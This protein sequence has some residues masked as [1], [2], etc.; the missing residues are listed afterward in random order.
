MN[1]E[2]QNLISKAISYIRS[3]YADDLTIA[4]VADHAGFCTDYFNR[5][6]RARTGFTVME[7]VRFTRLSRAAVLLR[8][9]SRDITDIAFECGYET[10]ES[11]TR[12]FGSLYGRSPSE[13]RSYYE[14]VPLTYADIADKTN[15]VR[16][17]HDHPA[18]HPVDTAVVVDELLQKDAIRYGINA[19]V[20][21]E[22][23]G[24]QFVSDKDGS[25]IGMDTFGN[26]VYADIV[27]DDPAKIA[28]Y[29]RLLRGFAEGTSFSLPG[30]KSDVVRTMEEYG[31]SAEPSVCWWMYRGDILPHTPK[32]TIR[33]LTVED[34]PAVK[35]FAAEYG[36][37][38]KVCESLTQRD[39]YH[40]ARGDEPLGIYDN[41]ELI[42]IFRTMIYGKYG[43]RIGELEG[44]AVLSRYKNAAFTREAY[45]M[46]INHLVGNSVM[47]F[48][49]TQEEGD[50]NPADY[51]F[52][53][54]NIVYTA[55]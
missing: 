15:A 37:D 40:N 4:D 16:F 46:A 31:I 20:M 41:G 6:F 28:E 49:C 39:V 22:Y 33:P 11:F 3:S 13:Y 52:D 44:A 42:A 51:G 38:W 32:F 55:K 18:F 5:L 14:T 7:Y 9:T 24:T 36:S 43:F 29:V 35:S 47:P 45:T 12:A 23:N 54:V 30:E 17:L 50:F 26:S 21:Y 2:T 10:H 48:C 25:Y 1:T 27:S 8:S 34:L 19:I 53:V